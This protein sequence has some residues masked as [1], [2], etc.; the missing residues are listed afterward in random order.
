MTQV[1]S[2]HVGAELLDYGR[3]II[4]PFKKRIIFQPNTKTDELTV[5]NS[6]LQMSI[7]PAGNR[8]SIGLIREGSE[9][10]LNGMRRG[11]VILKINDR[12]IPSVAAYMQFPFVKGETYTFTV[13]TEQGNIKKV[14]ITK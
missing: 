4:N 2:S 3:V 9:A 12:D 6:A 11:D 5:G 7:V 1:G 14:Q 10:Y 13:R 8:P